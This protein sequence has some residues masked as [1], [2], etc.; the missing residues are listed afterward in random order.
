M[1][2]W[3]ETEHDYKFLQTNTNLIATDVSADD[4]SI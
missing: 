4:Q 3:S 1:M 2:V